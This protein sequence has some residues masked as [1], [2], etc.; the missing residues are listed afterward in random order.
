M[1]GPSRVKKREGKKVGRER[2][3]LKRPYGCL[4]ELPEGAASGDR[5]SRW[6]ERNKVA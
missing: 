3:L 2:G 4:I 5:V 1:K 6:G